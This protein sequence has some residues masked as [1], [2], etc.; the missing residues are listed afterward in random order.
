MMAGW[1]VTLMLFSRISGPTE[2]YL[3]QPERMK[4]FYDAL[5]GKVTTPGPA[6]PVFRSSTE[7]MLLTSSLSITPNGEVHVPGNLEVWR[8]LF[9]KHPHGKYDG[10]LTRA[11]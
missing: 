7:L 6:R 3:T 1:Q 5:R 11:A 10:K 4:R 8:T 2:A 9:I